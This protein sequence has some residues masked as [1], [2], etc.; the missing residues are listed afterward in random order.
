VG[1]PKRL[2]AIAAL[3]LAATGITT[4]SA[5]AQTTATQPTVLYASPHGTGTTCSKTEPCG[6]NAAKSRVEQLN[7]HMTADIDVDLYGGTYHAPLTFGPKD[8]GTDGYTVTWQAAPGQ[9]P[10]ISGA[11]QIIGFTRYD[12][13]IYRARVSATEAS[14]GGQQLF[15]NGQRAELAQSDGPPPGL[16]VTSTGFYTTD[17]AYA[18]FTHQSQIQVVDNSDWKHESCPV[19]SITPA[20][21]GG[22]D[23]NVLPS[24]WEAN[25][26]DVPNLGFPYNGSGLPAM[27]SIS[28][29][30][31]A[32][33]L[34]TQPGQFY[35][36][37]TSRYL[38]YIPEPGQNM[39]TVN[40]ELPTEQDLLTLQGTPG[41]LAP[42]NQNAPG[43]TYT[44]DSWQDYTDRNLGDLDNDIEATTDNG[45]SVSYTFTGTGLEVLAE[46]YDDEGSFD[47][48]VDG[49][50]DTS[51]NFTEDT[52]GSTRL[53]QQ[54]VYSVQGLPQGTHTVTLVKTGGT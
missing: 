11:D 30:E 18:E 4:A 5:T 24:C 35:L 28:Y 47:A 52:S 43:T 41:H 14:T 51:Q 45:D 31:D 53:A 37:K 7:K 22:S 27:D 50:Q 21:G 48:Y 34:L 15:V 44:G 23:I 9:H 13:S 26:L 12:G 29:V 38:Y 33:E 8:S 54:V 25:N 20:T 16:Q 19:Q 36:D 46:T 10:V 32:Y 3:C 42:V 40:V 49:T 39:A 1:A 17:D 6:L 2:A